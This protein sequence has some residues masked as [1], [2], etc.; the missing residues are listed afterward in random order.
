MS[1]EQQHLH[2]A[3]VEHIRQCFSCLK[4]Q[5]E[6]AGKEIA[7][8]YFYLVDDFF[9]AGNAA[10]THQDLAA[11]AAKHRK[12]YKNCTILQAIWDGRCTLYEGKTE[13]QNASDN[14]LENQS[15]LYQAEY[16]SIENLD[17]DDDAYEQKRAEYETALIAAL[18]QCDQEGLFGN[19]VE[20][21]I[22][23]FAFYIDD[24]DEN[25]KQSLLYRSATQLNQPDTYQKL[26]G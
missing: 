11:F 13:I 15:E 5:T 12:K 4:Q 19:R 22:L 1:I 3:A 2:T 17:D 8:Y 6:Q 14:W 23:L 16:R 7:A 26:I 10:I 24:Y 25:D 21:G 9:A 20:N 18:Q